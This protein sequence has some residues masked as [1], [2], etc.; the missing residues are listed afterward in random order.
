MHPVTITTLKILTAPVRF[1]F[2]GVDVVA[3]GARLRGIR[4]WYEQQFY[5]SNFSLVRCMQPQA[6]KCPVVCFSSLLFATR[7]F[8]KRLPDI[9]QIL[10]NQCS[11]DIFSLGYKLFRYI[12]VYPIMSATFSTREP[13]KQPLGGGRRAFALNSRPD[14]TIP[15]SDNVKLFPREKKKNQEVFVDKS[16]LSPTNTIKLRREGK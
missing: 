6:V 15:I 13:S 7:L 10:K 9:S 11:T 5:S 16:C 14:S 2:N 3:S 8:V 12:M 4:W 1:A